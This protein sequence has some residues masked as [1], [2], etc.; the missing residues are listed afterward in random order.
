MN[1]NKDSTRYYSDAHEKSVCKALGATQQANSGAGHF[2]K[3]DVVQ[4]DASMMIECKC[5]MSPK[6]SIS[7]KREWFEQNKKEAY[8]MHLSNTAVCINFEP[9]GEN[10]YC[11]NERLMKV[12]IDALKDKPEEKKKE[13]K[14]EEPSDIDD[15]LGRLRGH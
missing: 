5:T 15:I 6:D 1:S 2:D 9:N 8:A 4:R 11:I 10:I 13:T 12:L 14:K 7:L 3:G